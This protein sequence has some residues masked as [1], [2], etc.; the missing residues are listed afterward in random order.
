MVLRFRG[1]PTCALIDSPEDSGAP[2]VEPA[3]R[4]RVRGGSGPRT[5]RRPCRL[6]HRIEGRILPLG[7]DADVQI[8]VEV[9]ADD[10]V[11]ITEHA[12]RAVAPAGRQVGLLARRHGRTGGRTHRAAPGIQGR[13]LIACFLVRRPRL[14]L[15]SRIAHGRTTAEDQKVQHA[16][17]PRLAG[18][19]FRSSPGPLA[20]PSAARWPCGAAA[21]LAAS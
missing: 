13:V 6:S 5:Q 10:C 14:L 8:R 4:V 21:S 20:H 15:P 19:V 7:G 9:L 1:R 16:S 18:H 2:H 17:L 12:L 11:E 3:T